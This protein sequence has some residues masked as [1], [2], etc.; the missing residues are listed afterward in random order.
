[1]KILGCK[2]YQGC[3]FGDKR[4]TRRA[5][6]I[7]ECLSVKYGQPLSTVFKSASDLKRA[8]EFLSNPK[9]TFSKL[10]EPCFKQTAQEI[11]GLPV[12]LAVGDTSFL[13]YKKILDKRDDYGPTGNGGN[14]LILHTSLA[15]DPDFGQPLGLLWEKLWHREKKALPPEV[16]TAQQKKQRLA[17]EGRAKRNKA[18]EEK[19]S[20]RWVEAFQECQK[21]FLDIE[22]PLGGLGTRIIHIFDREGDIAEVFVQACQIDNI[23]VV[24]RAAHNCC[25]RGSNSHLWEYVTSQPI[26][27]FKTVNLPETKKRSAR[28]ATLEVRFCP[29]SICPS[30]RVKSEGDFNVYA[31][32]AREIDAADGSEPVEWMLLT[33]EPLT[34]QQEVSQILR[35]YTYRWRV[36]EFH[37]IL[38]SGCKAESY[39]LAGESMSTMLG[40]L[41]V[42]AAQLLRITYLHRNS[43]DSNAAEVLTKVQMDVLLALTPPKLKNSANF[44]I[45]WAIR[46]IA[47][48]GGYLEHRKKT[49]IG[50]Q[51][52]W[53]GWLQLETLCQGWQLYQ[54]FN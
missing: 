48:L 34:S 9:T 54:N 43:P 32:Y 4:L 15:V 26:Q 27:F 10:T 12:V 51:V 45:D 36:E 3:D 53:K 39:R 13:N 2:P 24:V 29:V 18:F 20:Y 40:F 49:A 35:W 44:T 30:L 7:A 8:Y 19:E 14:G 38:K 23:G 25:L 5:V 52:L 50:I 37:K 28:I 41:T 46:A 31:V 47:R 16:E 22:T 6:S 11:Y 33:T 17:E 1:M 42:I 21:L